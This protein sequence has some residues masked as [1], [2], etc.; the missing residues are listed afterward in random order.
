[1]RCTRA[2]LNEMVQIGLSPIMFI[3]YVRFIFRKNNLKDFIF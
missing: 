1:M 3:C 2:S